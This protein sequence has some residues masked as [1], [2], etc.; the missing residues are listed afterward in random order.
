MDIVGH[1]RRG[2][3]QVQCKAFSTVKVLVQESNTQSCALGF[4]HLWRETV[5][6][7]SSAIPLHSFVFLNCTLRSRLPSIDLVR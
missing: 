2:S 5:D 7:S 3:L 6:H 4:E 1:R